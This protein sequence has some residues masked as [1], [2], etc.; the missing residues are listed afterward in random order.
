MLNTSNPDLRDKYSIL[1]AKYFQPFINLFH[2]LYPIGAKNLCII[3]LYNDA[4][5]FPLI[6][7]L[8]LQSRNLNNI[9]RLGLPRLSAFI[10]HFAISAFKASFE[11]VIFEPP[12]AWQRIH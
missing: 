1:G 3:D 9:W 12:T 11:S 4:S 6:F 8:S 2:T 10:I 7:G 5:H